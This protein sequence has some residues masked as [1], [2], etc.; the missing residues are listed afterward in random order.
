MSG[1]RERTAVTALVLLIA[2]GTVHAAP[3]WRS[4]AGDLLTEAQ[5]A[6]VR[7]SGTAASQRC[8]DEVS[9]ARPTRRVPTVHRFRSI[10][11]AE[12]PPVRAPD[13]R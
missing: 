4:A 10:A 5:I 8:A 7:V 2:L 12:L 13:R 11:A 9:L 6:D 3:T 1:A